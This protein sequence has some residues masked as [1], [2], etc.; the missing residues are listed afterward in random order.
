[1]KRIKLFILITY[2]LT[3]SVSQTQAL[4]I[5]SG[6]LSVQENDS[7][8]NTLVYNS[9]T[10]DM[11]GGDILSLDLLNSSTAD[12]S[13][14]SITQGLY[15]WNNST[16]NM[17]DGTIG[18]N[19]DASDSSTINLYGGEITDWLY[20]TDD[21]VVNIYGYG[22]NY[23][24]D[25]GGWNG[26]QLTGFWLDDTPFTIDLLDNIE[27]DSTYYDHVNL[28][29]EPCSLILIGFGGLLLRRRK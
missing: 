20:A 1:M 14:G 17:T 18:W 5:Y 23:D 8:S 2:I 7:Y 19:L 29:P 4:S 6:T 22:F 13:G 3:I 15:V 10:V 16:V 28:V 27:V 25:A 21:S 9:A 24:S 11:T 26:G 12:I